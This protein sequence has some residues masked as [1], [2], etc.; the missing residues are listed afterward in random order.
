MN[1]HLSDVETLRANARARIHEGPLTSEY[2]ADQRRVVNVLNEVL[3][4]E[5]VCALRYKR[6][7]F[8]ASEIDAAPVAA[9]FLQHAKEEQT[10]AD[11]IAARSY[12]CKANPI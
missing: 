3:A 6:H 10:H 5:L 1:E 7:H 9:E 4:T 8:M 12:S 11:L 2:H